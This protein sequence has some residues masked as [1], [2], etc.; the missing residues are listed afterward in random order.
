MARLPLT[1]RTPRTPA[2]RT[3]SRSYGDRLNSLGNRARKRLREIA[4]RTPAGQVA[5]LAYRGTKSF[6]PFVSKKK[7]KSKSVG[8]NL[9]GVYQ[10]KFKKGKR[11][12]VNQALNLGFV[13]TTEVTGSVVDP[14]CVY[15]GHS[16]AAPHQCLELIAQSMIRKL[17]KKA[18]LNIIQIDANLPGYAA[19]FTGNTDCWRLEIVRQ[20]P[21]TGGIETNTYDTV[22]ND[23]I[24]RI[25]GNR[26]N[27]IVPAWTGLMQR[28]ELYCNPGNEGTLWELVELNLYYKDISLDA[29][30]PILKSRMRLA[31]E[32]VHLSFKSEL[33]IQN[34]S[35][36]AGG[37]TQADDVS[38]NPLEGRF[39][40]FNT[41]VPRTNLTFKDQPFVNALPEMTGVILHRAGLL[42]QGLKEPPEPRIFT[43]VKSAGRIKLEPGGIKKDVLTFT[44]KGKLLKVL[45][46][47][48]FTT[49]LASQ[50]FNNRVKGVSS[51]IALEDMINVNIEHDIIIAYEVNRVQSCYLT[52]GK[53][54]PALGYFYTLDQTLIPTG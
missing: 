24:Y 17:F 40:R 23:S 38:N 19:A 36:A 34:R 45:K 8:F 31:L 29:R 42:P 13:H 1:P 25:V 43:S 15:I 52:T 10:G 2:R 9:S 41:G 37:S 35:R 6:N 46:E 53:D 51:M 39:Y 18:G 32:N 4:M 20:N 50:R 3:P 12:K 5:N 48:G 27:G 26:T 28:L 21:E 44:Y 11:P 7:K 49:Q 47:F 54:N 30:F 14:N 16:S 33:K 22:N